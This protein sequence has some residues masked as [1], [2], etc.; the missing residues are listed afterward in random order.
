M[1]VNF[2]RLQ[3]QWNRRSILIRWRKNMHLLAKCVKPT[4]FEICSTTS[5]L[6]TII[7]CLNWLTK[8]FDFLK[9]GFY[10]KTSF[11]DFCNF[12]NFPWI[13]HSWQLWLSLMSNSGTK[14]ISLRS[15]SWEAKYWFLRLEMGVAVAVD[16]I[17]PCSIRVS[18]IVFSICY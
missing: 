1:K 7:K 16:I 15:K 8:L 5:G 4:T 12:H 9:T 13:I 11:C 10:H 3:S 6:P 18:P 2:Y 17:G 14:H